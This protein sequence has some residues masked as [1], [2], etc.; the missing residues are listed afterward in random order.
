V[1]VPHH[2]VHGLQL[3]RTQ[4]GSM[5]L[6]ILPCLFLLQACF[7]LYNGDVAGTSPGLIP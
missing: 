6:L 7:V 5:V 2:T 3:S 4:T 1:P